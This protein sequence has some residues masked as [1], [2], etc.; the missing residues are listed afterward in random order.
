MIK[1]WLGKCALGKIFSATKRW[2]KCCWYW[3]KGNGPRAAGSGLPGM[4][5]HCCNLR[6][7]VGRV[8]H[9]SCRQARMAERREDAS[10]DDR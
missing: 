4:P 10:L 5:P 7:V 9:L 8:I 3:G 6:W 1:Q 2:A